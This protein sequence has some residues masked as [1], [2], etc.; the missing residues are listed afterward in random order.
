MTKALFSAFLFILGFGLYIA[1]VKDL[2]FITEAK[3]YLGLEGWEIKMIAIT[4]LIGG[5]VLM[6]TAVR[7]PIPTRRHRLHG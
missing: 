3:L 1:F 6:T 7:Q 4:A 2:S 5:M